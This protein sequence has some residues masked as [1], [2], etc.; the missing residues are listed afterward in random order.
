MYMR[1]VNIMLF[2]FTFEKRDVL[3]RHRNKEGLL[4]DEKH[5]HRG[6]KLQHGL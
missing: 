6:E 5:P 3:G 2:C 1:V 4:G